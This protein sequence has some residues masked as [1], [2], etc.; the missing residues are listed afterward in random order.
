MFNAI[1]GKHF[2]NGDGIILLQGTPV[3]VQKADF[4]DF[5][6]FGTPRNHYS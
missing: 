1:C 4:H 2:Q 6:I 5:L 3:K